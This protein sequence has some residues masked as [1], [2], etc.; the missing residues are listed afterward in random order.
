[1]LPKNDGATTMYQVLLRHLSRICL[2]DLADK[3]YFSEPLQKILKDVL[4][5]LAFF[6]YF[7]SVTHVF[8]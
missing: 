6:R 3:G 8:S 5:L 1:M 7:F 2:A 4:K